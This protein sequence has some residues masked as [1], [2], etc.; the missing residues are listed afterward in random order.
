MRFDVL[1]AEEDIARFL[2]Y[3]AYKSKAD[4]ISHQ[5]TPHYLRWKDKVGE[6]MAQPRSGVKHYSLFPEDP[7][8]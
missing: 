6:W 5:Q 2:L 3:E 4:F 8:F 7:E 1:Q